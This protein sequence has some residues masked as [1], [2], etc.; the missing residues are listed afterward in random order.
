MSRAV[1]MAPRWDVRGVAAVDGL[2]PGQLV[3]NVT[4][5]LRVAGRR[6]L[7]SQSRYSRTGAT[8]NYGSLKAFESLL[9]CVLKRIHGFLGGERCASR[10]NDDGLCERFPA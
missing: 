4:Q 7:S 2:V 3:W 6:N 1:M 8:G 9:H 10:E 5:H